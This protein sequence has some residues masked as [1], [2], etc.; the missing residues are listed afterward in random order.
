M[1]DKIPRRACLYLHVPAET[2]ITAAI[3]AV[4]NLGADVRLTEAVNLL[5][6]ARDK[7][8][9]YIDEQLGIDHD[10]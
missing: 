3:D 10:R 4:E 6:E 5:S 1:T 8:S 7:V 2:A 9:D